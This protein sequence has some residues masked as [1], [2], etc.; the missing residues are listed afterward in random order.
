MLQAA[1]LPARE[2]KEKTIYT[3]E[4][5]GRLRQIARSRDHGKFYQIYC[6]ALMFFSGQDRK[7]VVDA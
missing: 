4:A 3:T 5:P 6:R 2:W 1:W 7:A